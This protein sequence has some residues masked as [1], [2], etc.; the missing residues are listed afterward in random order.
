MESQ[1]IKQGIAQVDITTY[2]EFTKY[3][4]SLDGAYVFRGQACDWWEL[5]PSFSNLFNEN[6][7]GVYAQDAYN[8]TQKLLAW[9]REGLYQCVHEVPFLRGCDPSKLDDM[10]LWA[11]RT[12]L[13]AS[14]SNP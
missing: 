1:V 4:A 12:P 9:F 7:N 8:L 3:V 2:S 6:E 10:N 13:R 14:Y 11:H 5:R